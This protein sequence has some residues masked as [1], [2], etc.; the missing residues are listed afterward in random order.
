MSWIIGNGSICHMHLQVIADVVMLLRI[1][2]L[3]HS[4]RDIRLCLI[5]TCNLTFSAFGC[6]MLRRD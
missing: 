3:L 6:H 5:H 4:V 2:P 1:L